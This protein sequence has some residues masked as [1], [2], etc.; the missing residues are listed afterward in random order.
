[1]VD[2]RAGHE[3]GFLQRAP[4]RLRRLLQVGH[5]LSAHPARLGLADAQDPERRAARRLAADLEDDRTR[6]RGPDLQSRKEIRTHIS[7][8]SQGPA[9]PRPGPGTVNRYD[10]PVPPPPSPP[11]RRASGE[12]AR[13]EARPPPPRGAPRTPT[14]PAGSAARRPP[15]GP[16]RAPRSGPQSPRPATGSEDTTPRARP[17][18]RRDGHPRRRR[19]GPRGRGGPARRDPARPAGSGQPHRP[20]RAP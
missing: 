4:D 2:R 10:A 9:R 18:R 19:P 14:A 13:D 15:P 16:V 6:L 3:L 12:A 11:G 7:F 8:S 1:P 17:P 5:D 20:R